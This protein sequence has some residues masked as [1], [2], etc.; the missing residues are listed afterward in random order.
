VIWSS[1]LVTVKMSAK[2]VIQK[3]F[4]LMGYHVTRRKSLQSGSDSALP[5]LFDDPLEALCYQQGGKAAAFRCPLKYVVKSNALSYSPDGW[6]PFVATLREYAAGEST[7]YE[8]SVLRQFYETH[9]PENAAEAIAGFDQAPSDYENHPAHVYRLRPWRSRAADWVD[10]N[11]RNWSELDAREHGRSEHDWS[12]DEDGYQFHG[13]VSER[14]GRLEYQRLTDIYER[15]KAEGYDRTRGH[16]HFQV[17]RRDGECCF[18]NCGSGSHRTA[19]M[20][21]LGHKTIPAVFTK[22]HVVDVEMVEYW[23]QVR[24]GVWTKEQAEAY[25]NHLFDFE[26][27]SWA[28]E[29]GLL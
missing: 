18:L 11:V 25:F 19:A 2:Q 28:R 5:P 13:P 26:S 21:A 15:L 22:N 6:H 4:H 16:A 3:V 12:F 23:P 24:R 10:Q 1:D 29:R 17:L 7:G 8:D 14:I 20:A 9:Q 27:K